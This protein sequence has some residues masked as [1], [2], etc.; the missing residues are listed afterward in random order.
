MKDALRYQT[1]IRGHSIDTLK[2][3]MVGYSDGRLAT[4]MSQRYSEA[5]LLASGMFYRRNGQLEDLP[6]AGVYVYPH[7]VDGKVARFTFKDPTGNFKFQQPKRSWLPGA[8]WYG[9]ESLDRPGDIA[10]VE[11]E[12]DRLALME[13]YDGPVLASIG[14]VSREQ[15][16]FIQ[17]LVGEA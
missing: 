9:Q 5:S 2:A 17:T 3:A 1:E 10:L 6:P 14:S 12:N 11:G 4:L 16:E 13:V 7:F 8:F 15:V